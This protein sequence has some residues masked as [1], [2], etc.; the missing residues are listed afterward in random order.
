[1]KALQSFNARTE[2][3]TNYRASI[4]QWLDFFI[5]CLPQRLV[6]WVDRKA[7]KRAV[8]SR[9]WKACKN[10]RRTESQTIDR[11]MGIHA[12]IGIP[13]QTRTDQ[14]RS[15]QRPRGDDGQGGAC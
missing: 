2:E 15:D 5:C 12:E 14:T 9:L 6:V 3:D 7:A 1:M 10:R 11:R 13:E 4:N 8:W